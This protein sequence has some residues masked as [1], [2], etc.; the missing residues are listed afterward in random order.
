MKPLKAKEF[1]GQIKKINVMIENKLAEAEH[2]KSVA[3]GITSGGTDVKINGVIHQMDKVQSTGSQQKMADAINKYVDLEA[4]INAD[5]DKLIDTR[6]N[7]IETIELLE[8]E[9]YDLLHKVYVQGF[10]LD[11]VAAMYDFSYS[12]ATTLHG[13]A[14]KDVEKILDERGVQSETD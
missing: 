5:I 4:E 9:K 10:T 2:W 14:L 7:I 13:R 12:W 8:A 1:L 6:K 3:L 11:E